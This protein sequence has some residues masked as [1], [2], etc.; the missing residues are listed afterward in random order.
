MED[1]R[2]RLEA[3]VKKGV[4][5]VSNQHSLRIVR[6]VGATR[7]GPGGS[8]RRVLTRHR[9]HGY[10]GKGHIEGHLLHQSIHGPTGHNRVVD[11]LRPIIL[12][13]VD[14]VAVDVVHQVVRHHV[15][16]QIP[17]V[18][19]ILA[20]SDS[21]VVTVHLHGLHLELVQPTRCHRVCVHF[22]EEESAVHSHELAA[23]HAFH[24]AL[25]NGVRA[26]HP[27]LVL[28]IALIVILV[29]LRAQLSGH[30]LD[31]AEA[32]SPV[33]H[34]MAFLEVGH[35]GTGAGISRQVLAVDQD[36]VDVAFAG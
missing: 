12:Q 4:R 5:V 7:H 6:L 16:E 29:L 10:L 13:V 15:L 25:E 34:G 14:G 26:L 24:D 23:V 19:E 36:K 9:L 1:V 3:G 32:G 20:A 11:V 35:C 27:M 22:H 18:P 30:V 2:A 33:V 31:T 8:E 17:L 21:H 28:R